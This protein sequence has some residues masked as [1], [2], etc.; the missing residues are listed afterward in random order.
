MNTIPP[1]DPR[2]TR[3]ISV[4]AYRGWVML[5]MMAEVLQLKKVSR[6]LPENQLLAFLAHHQDHVNWAGCVL[7]DMI[8]PSFSFL[9]GVALPLSLRRRTQ[10]HQPLWRRTVHAAWRAMAL[11][12]LGVFLRSTHSTQTRWTFEDTL[13]QI[14]LGYVFLYLIAQCSIRIQCGAVF[15]ILVG[16]WLLFA[17]YP[18]PGSDFDWGRIQNSPEAIGRLTGFAAH[19]NLNTNPAWGFDKWFLNLFPREKP[20]T[21]NGGGYSTLNFIPTLATMILGLLAGG[22]LTGDRSV[23]GKLTWLCTAGVIALACGYGLD[24]AGICPIVKKIWTPSWVLFSGGWCFLIL[25]AF[26]SV[27]DV[28]NFRAWSFPLVVVGMNSIAA[29][30]IAHLWDDFIARA[31]QTHLGES[32]FVVAGKEYQPLLTGAA[33]LLI[34]W[35]ILLWMYRRRIFLRI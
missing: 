33:V 29:Y 2:S 28:L 10:E 32:L 13:S 25:A 31:L 30:L 15:T 20:F 23:R 8:Q 6:A 34:E 16:Y 5:L 18:L 21:H 27:I 14:G 17:L 35:L 4:D 9:V 19:W 11:I 26:Y 7:H 1:S 3:L 12:L 24:A 22:V